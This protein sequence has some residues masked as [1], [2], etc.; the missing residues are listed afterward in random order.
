M[1]GGDVMPGPQIKNW[2]Q[3]HALRRKGMDKRTA[4]MIT[5]K[6]SKIKRIN[7]RKSWKKRR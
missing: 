1:Q 4:A 3:Y 5:N 7:R 2:K 6:A